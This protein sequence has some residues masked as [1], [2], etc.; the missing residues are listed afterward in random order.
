MSNTRWKYVIAGVGVLLLAGVV[1]AWSVLSVSIAQEFPDWS[2]AKLSVTFTLVMAL[3]CTGQIACGFLGTRLKPRTGIWIGGALLLMGFILAARMTSIIMLYLGFGVLGGLGTGVAYISVMSS[4]V[5]WFPDKRG[6]V[7]GILL[8][9]FG[10]S[11][12]LIGKLFQ[13]YTPA[14]AGAWRTSF[15]VLGAVTFVVLFVCGFFVERPAEEP[16]A[17]MSGGE[18][19]TAGE[20]LKKPRFWLYYIWELLLTCCGLMIIAHASGVVAETS[21]A[22]SAGAAATLVGLISIANGFGRVIF[23]TL[24]DKAGRR[25]SMLLICVCFAAA[26]GLLF[27][28]VKTSS[29]VL[30]VFAFV[31]I[32]MGYGGIPVSN[33]A[34]TGESF[35]MAH[36]HTNYP[37]CNSA[38]LP[39]SFGGTIAGALYDSSQSFYGVFA[40]ILAFAALSLLCTGGITALEKRK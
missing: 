35:G 31:L 34:F 36:Y 27:L 13:A 24:Y 22:I 40:V 18:G 20:M 30:L 25:K 28:A 39:A 26:V 2:R 33:S 19:L 11:S 21:P 10:F 16:A 4:V 3:F 15:L 6:L 17:A 1:Y 12:F 8:M 9:G 7:S 32:G 37:L 29:T 23:G 38:M 14:V 5:K